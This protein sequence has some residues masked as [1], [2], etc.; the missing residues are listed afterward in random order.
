M[1]GRTLTI[2]LLL[3]L[4]LPPIP[5]AAQ[6]IDMTGFVRGLYR[7]YLGREPSPEEQVAWVRALQRGNAASE[8]HAFIMA[9]D[10]CFDRY[11]RDVYA[12]IRGCYAIVLNRGPAERDLVFWSDK[13]AR[14]GG[15]RLRWGRE[16][17]RGADWQS[18]SFANPPVIVP[19]ADLP[20]RLVTTC[21]L[22]VGAVTSEIPGQR[23]W[24]AYTQANNLLTS[25]RAN[26]L[27][28]SNP[29]GNPLAYNQA[30]VSLQ[31]ANDALRTTLSQSGAAVPTSRQYADQIYNLLLA[32]RESGPSVPLPLP[33][34]PPVNPGG[35]DPVTFDR[36]QILL[37]N[38]N[39]T[40]TQFVYVV[41]NTY[42][43]DWT[44]ERLQGNG[45]DFL[46]EIDRFRSQVRLGG[47]VAD[48]RTGYSNLRIQADRISAQ[49][50]R[51][52]Y[53]RRIQQSWYDT[54]LTFNKLAEPLGF[55]AMELSE[56]WQ[57]VPIIGVGGTAP[58]PINLGGPSAPTVG[59][60]VLRNLDE[61]I[62]QCDI[63]SAA[64]TPYAYQ[65]PLIV[66]VQNEL[67]TL[68]NSLVDLRRLAV[69]GSSRSQMVQALT[70][71]AEDARRVQALWNRL[72][73]GPG[74]P[75]D[76]PDL[77]AFQRSFEQVNDPNLFGP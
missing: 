49:M 57:P 47:A 25:V 72:V 67:R 6:S 59:Q 30:V 48:L 62:S 73:N 23:G 70:H 44:V 61:S 60:T 58:L 7:D 34:P 40:G 13:L 51:N 56:S 38:L 27:L 4:A 28:L 71:A 9:S 66:S 24:L 63:A 18:P 55:A 14:L 53:D 16:F 43:R 10:E 35:L 64:L 45:E 77:T 31:T 1:A 50:R 12:W 54:V 69:Q 32:L 46:A 21:E 76:L 65:N 26:R 52:N 19:P 15:D 20:T 3:L 11:R 74:V 33:F 42:P 29:N 2:A 39:Q 22:L 75:R 8:V 68:R 41:R 17:L 36:L 5:A 37:R